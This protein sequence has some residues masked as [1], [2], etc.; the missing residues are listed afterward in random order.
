MLSSS[1][2]KEFQCTYHTALVGIWGEIKKALQS[3]F[4]SKR[5][6]NVFTE[7]FQAIDNYFW[8]PRKK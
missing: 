6:S 1:K 7:G 5:H 8:G 3:Q 2:S 4:E